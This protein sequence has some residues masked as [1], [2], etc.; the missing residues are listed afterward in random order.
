MTQTRRQFLATAAAI[1]VLPMP[2]FASG[3]DTFKTA[4]GPLTVHPVTHASLVLETPA[5]NVLID[6]ADSPRAYREYP[7][8]DL[9]LITHHH[10]D[11]YKPNTIK[12][13]MGENTKLITNPHVYAKLPS[14]LMKRATAIKNGETL[15]FNGLKLE[16]IPAYNLD[17]D[18]H[19]Y[20]PPGR[21]NGY[22]LSI[23]G[24]KTYVAG[25]TDDIPEMR[26]LRNID[27]AF[28]CMTRPYTMGPK[29]A[30]DAVSEFKPKVVYPYH[31]GK[32][33]NAKTFAKLVGD[34]A[35]VRMGGWYS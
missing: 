23:G 15:D 3:G 34:K 13:L 35:E 4:K 17:P 30:A 19:K 11:H 28:L 7:A 29:A 22:V 26:A 10:G 20:H 32:A 21:D 5:G 31:Y 24:F 1:T 27:L 9:I 8:P 6:P 33:G 2:S 12:A 18:F 14:A 25:D 16:A